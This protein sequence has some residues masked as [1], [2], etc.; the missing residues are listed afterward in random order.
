MNAASC[1]PFLWRAGMVLM[2]TMM[3]LTTMAGCAS[4]RQKQFKRARRDYERASVPV[5][6][7]ADEQAQ[8]LTL[9]TRKFHEVN[10]RWPYSLNELAAFAAARELDFN[11]FA[12]TRMTI[13]LMPD[14]AAQIQ[15]EV[16]CA[17]FNTMQYRF[18]M[19]GNLHLTPP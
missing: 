15:Y 7:Y 11:P 4:L 16:D 14:G 3:I 12:F 13:A 18:R 10:R 8:R 2:A 1:Q 17:R 5:R 9:T 19:P 6:K